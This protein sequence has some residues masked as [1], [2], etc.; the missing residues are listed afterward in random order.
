MVDTG[1]MNGHPS[2]L[3]RRG[4]R[5][6]VAVGLAALALFAAACSSTGY[7]YIKSSDDRTYFKVPEKWTLFDEDALT[8]GL[9]PREREAALETSWQIGFDAS[10]KPKLGHLLDV[11]S[12]HP[13][14][15]ALVQELDFDSADSV[16]LS[17]LRNTFF[18]IDTAVQNQAGEIISYEPMEL[19]GGF[20]GFRVVADLDTD[21]GHTMTVDQT[22]LLDQATSKMYVLLVTCRAQCYADN[23]DQIDRVVKSWTVED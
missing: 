9:T 7:S 19:D 5:V 13:N 6:P 20:H 8:K 1:V 3:R 10:P 21:D 14:G 15:I 22:T 4:A 12:K 11:G 2:R 18:D 16:S 23:S 17:G